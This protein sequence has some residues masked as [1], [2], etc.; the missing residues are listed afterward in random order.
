MGG[1][2]IAAAAQMKETDRVAIEKRGIPSEVLMERAARHVAEAAEEFLEKR[3]KG[4]ASSGEA[5]PE[6]GFRIAVFC[7]P[8]NNGGDGV[9]AAR[10][11][12][13]KGMKVRAFLVGS[14]EKLT[15]DTRLMEER[16]REAGLL[17]EDWQAEA[18]NSEQKS[19]CASADLILD[20][21]LG[22]GLRGEVRP[23]M[24]EVILWLDSLSVPVLAVDIASGIDTDTGAVLGAALH[25]SLTVT[26]TLPKFGHYEGQGSCHAGSLKV[27]DIGIP[28]A[29]VDQVLSSGTKIRAE[30]TGEESGAGEAGQGYAVFEACDEA[31]ARALLPKRREDGHKGTFGKVSITGGSVGFSGAPV[32]ASRGAARCGSGLVF[33]GVPESIYSITAASCLEVMPSPLP[34]QGG[35][36]SSGA[37]FQILERLNACDA[38]LI[39]P[40]LG[41][42]QELSLLVCKLLEQTATPLVLDADGLYAVKDR[43]E[44]LKR[45]CEKGLVTILTPHEGEFAYLGGDLSK[46][47]KTA[48]LR[49]AEK[50]GCILVLKGPATVTASPEGKA[51]INTTG[52]NGMA[53]GG[54]GDVL[55]GMVLSFLGQGMEP[56]KAAALAVYLHGLAGDLCRDRLGEYG[57]LPGDLAEE[58]PYAILRLQRGC[59]EELRTW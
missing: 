14:R 36:I 16:L 50:Y 12:K 51:Y 2:R 59:G 55:G 18:E 39:G 10:F 48:A 31:C 56:L 27:C 15:A 28:E 8:G 11:L 37:F 13:E 54:S 34:N 5:A 17:L 23:Q 47:R 40:G 49:F 25:A 45:R 19:W 22:I 38:G 46:G 21:L 44:L 41:R 33:L 35:R 7:G 1:V 42:S 57:M 26:F 30:K 32:L 58:I 24:K 3:R 6:A 4:P 53:K 20:A 29:V 43:K 52:N 9:A